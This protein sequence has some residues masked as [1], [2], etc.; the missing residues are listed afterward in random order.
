[1]HEGCGDWLRELTAEGPD[2]LGPAPGWGRAKF[3][4]VPSRAGGLVV[5]MGGARESGAGNGQRIAVISVIIN[6]N[7]NKD[8]EERVT[9]QAGRY[10]PFRNVGK[11]Y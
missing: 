7:V 11:N 4:S 9:R 1:M 3:P 6:Y 5:C 8:P 2:G 10:Y